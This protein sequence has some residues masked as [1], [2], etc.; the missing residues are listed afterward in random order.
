MLNVGKGAPP[1]HTTV[2]ER[3]LALFSAAFLLCCG[4]GDD[5]YAPAR[6]L[7]PPVPGGNGRLNGSAVAGVAADAPFDGVLEISVGTNVKS[8]LGAIHAVVTNAAGEVVG[9]AD[10][11]VSNPALAQD[12]SLALVLPSG[13]GFNV[14]LSAT[15]A[16]SRPTVCRA[17]IDSLRLEAG[18]T[19]RVQVFSWDCGGVSGYVPAVAQPDCY[20]LAD[21]AFVTRTSAIV[22]ALIGVRAAAHDA[23]GNPAQLS[24]SSTLPARGSF[25][26]PAA[27]QTSFRCEAAGNL[28]VIALANDGECTQAV[29]QT[30]SC[31]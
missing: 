6:S 12:R 4:A 19:A 29:T 20:W 15:T 7:S 26:D 9:G 3:C 31:L 28:D 13:D 5:P 24:W 11:E 10:E 22:G 1:E 30:V 16:D 17:A 23:Q 8:F 25:A 18:A 21:Y 14:R 27:A 2:T